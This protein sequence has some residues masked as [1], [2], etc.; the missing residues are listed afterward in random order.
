M[1]II[2]LFLIVILYVL[3]EQ[4]KKDSYSVKQIKKIETL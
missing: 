3:L 2:L 1:Y 4:T